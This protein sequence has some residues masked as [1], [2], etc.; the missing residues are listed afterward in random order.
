V[1]DN[2]G[3]LDFA[4]K[5]AFEVH[6][7]T[8]AVLAQ[9]HGAENFDGDSEVL[10]RGD[11]HRVDQGV[12]V[13]VLGTAVAS[14]VDAVGR[15]SRESSTGQVAD[16]QTNTGGDHH[17]RDHEVLLLT[18]I[19]TEDG[20]VVVGDEVGGERRV[21]GH[22]T[23]GL[24]AETLGPGKLASGLHVGE[25]L[26]TTS[27]VLEERVDTSGVDGGVV[28]EGL[29]DGLQLDLT[30]LGVGDGTENGHSRFLEL[31]R[32]WS[33]SG[34]ETPA[35]YSAGGRVACPEIA[36]DVAGV[37]RLCDPRAMTA[38]GSRDL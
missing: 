35:L 37:S 8:E 5:L 30:R 13:P 32:E 20:V 24:D 23:E 25:E 26:V 17:R 3:L 1:K 28:V 19:Q 36:S 29:V 34:R 15:G 38:R 31:R 7:E 12:D 33:R 27:G 14:V 4:Q 11:V 16:F 22:R 21:G 18:D 10:D 6:V 2:P 9:G